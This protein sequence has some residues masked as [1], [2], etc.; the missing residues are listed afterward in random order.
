MSK[1]QVVRRLALIG[2][3]IAGALFFWRKRKTREGG[4]GDEPSSGGE[5]PGNSNGDE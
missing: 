1:G 5:A 3:A 4:S 2:S